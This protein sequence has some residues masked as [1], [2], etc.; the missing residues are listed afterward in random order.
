MKS[1]HAENWIVACCVAALA[2]LPAAAQTDSEIAAAGRACMTIGSQELRL[3]CFEGVFGFAAAPPES[4]AVTSRAAAQPAAA[5]P[6]VTAAQTP[7]ATPAAEEN[8]EVSAA[9]PEVRIVEVREIRPGDARF[10]TEE[11]RVYISTGRISRNAR[12]P[13][14]P[15]TA[16]LE[17]GALGRQ[18]LRF[19]PE[20]YE[21]VRVSER[22]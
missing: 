10:L 13:E 22:D 20:D 6:A 19:G 7:A 15:F 9:I 18:F 2:H 5:T 8:T 16:T 4:A 21:R 11:G 3:A 17:S 1:T 14:A 12:F